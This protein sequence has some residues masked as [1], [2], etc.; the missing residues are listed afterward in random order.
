MNKV[1]E[2]IEKVPGIKKVELVSKE[3]CLV[4]FEPTTF[5]QVI[6]KAY[7]EG[8]LI[9]YSPII[10]DE[11]FLLKKP[12]FD[13][14]HYNYRIADLCEVLESVANCNP[15]AANALLKWFGSNEEF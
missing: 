10:G 9:E 14:E 15:S 4:I 3:R 12:V 6:E 5:E 1:I 8:K 11:W 13:F 7:E 2:S